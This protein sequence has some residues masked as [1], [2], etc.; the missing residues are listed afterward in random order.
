MVIIEIIEKET[1][2]AVL[3]LWATTPL[4]LDDPFM[5]AVYQVLTLQF[6]TGAKLRSCN[7]TILCLGLT[8]V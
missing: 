4:G 5:G 6:M 8:T 1:R 7:E 2:S 3:N